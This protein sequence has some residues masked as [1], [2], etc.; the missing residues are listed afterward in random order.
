MSSRGSDLE[1]AYASPNVLRLQGGD[2]EGI[3]RH[4]RKHASNVLS[5]EEDKRAQTAESAELGA[6]EAQVCRDTRRPAI[7]SHYNQ[8]GGHRRPRQQRLL[9]WLHR[10]AVDDAWLT[11]CR[12]I[13]ESL[14]N[15]GLQQVVVEI[16]DPRAFRPPSVF[17]VLRTD[18]ECE[19]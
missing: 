17:P 6:P 3:E 18:A 9:P 10:Q 13:R 19:K 11:D 12:Q 1:L 16:A 8:G 7:K 2:P 14:I 5:D 15:K 4:T